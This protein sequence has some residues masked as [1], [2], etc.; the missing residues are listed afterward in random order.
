MKKILRIGKGIKVRRA[1]VNAICEVPLDTMDVDVKAELIQMLIPIGLLHVKKLLEEEVRQFAG[2]RYKRDGFP[3]YDRWGKQ[4]GSICLLDQK[5]PIMIPRVRDQRKRK[6]VRLKTYER[7]QKPRDREEGVLKRILH[8]LSC[9][10]YEECA[11]AVPEAF[12]MSGS[13]VSR[14][15]IRASARKLLTLCL[16]PVIDKFKELYPSV[17]VIVREG[18]RFGSSK[19]CSTSSSTSVSL[20]C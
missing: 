6:E 19:T 1:R 7:L 13:T 3:G 5:L 9:R 8:G 15:Y 16:T 2:E 18:P 4:G 14:G 10:S 17:K 11:G 12:G 20:G